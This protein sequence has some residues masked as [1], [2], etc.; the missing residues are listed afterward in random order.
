[1]R[2]VRS[3]PHGAFV[4]AL[5]PFV[6]PS[7]QPPFQ[8]WLDLHCALTPGVQCGLVMSMPA[9]ARASRPAEDGTPASAGSPAVAATWPRRL[10]G[11]QELEQLAAS[12]MRRG[13]LAVHRPGGADKRILMAHPLS[14][15]G[16]SLLSA[17]AISFIPQLPLSDDDLAA[18]GRRAQA[19]LQLLS[20]TQDPTGLGH[21]A[22]ALKVL[23]CTL[24]QRHAD[25][26]ASACAD[27]LLAGLGCE[28]VA[29][30]LLQGADL[31]FA[32][33]APALQMDT[34]LPLARAINAAMH[35][36]LDQE[37]PVLLNPALPASADEPRAPIRLMH[38]QLA[39]LEPGLATLSVP[40]AVEGKPA[41]VV[42]LQRRAEA[43]FDA[44]AALL[45]DTV[46]ALAGPL[47]RM[48]QQLH[49][50]WPQRL[51]LAWHGRLAGR[52]AAP[53]NRRRIAIAAGLVVT[54]A[55]GLVPID[56]RIS[57][58]ARVEGAVERSLAAPVDGFIRE[59]SALPGDA[60][61]SGQVLVTLDDED[62]TIELQR[63]EGELGQAESQY[64]DA[65][66]R[67]DR[68]QIAVQHAR[69]ESARAQRDL[70]Q[71]QLSRT[72]LV[73]P[74]DATVTEGDLSRAIGSPVKRGDVLVKL[75]P[76]ADY[77]LMLDVDERD[78]AQVALGAKG[79]VTLAAASDRNLPVTVA[80]VSPVSVARDGHNVFEVEAKLNAADAQLRPGL[81][82][83]ARLDAGQRPLAAV[84]LRRSWDW[85]RLQAWSWFG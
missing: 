17:G 73:A 18:I 23:A 62:A 60:V 78:I 38:G 70:A 68:A 53:R 36:A 49:G 48:K 63:A 33:V 26:A 71:R 56:F 34:R 41:G 5:N 67:Q 58:Q 6:D 59:V 29:I 39:R 65:V 10:Q 14:Q 55:V 44:H 3:V 85:L 12:A 27:E 37:V 31:R 1:M 50:P 2:H 46:M 19:W 66:G 51:R 30:A 45:V 15:P 61:K 40:F 7:M 20:T 11:A 24:Q 69:M 28:R 75:V 57:A 64:N 72:R 82:G 9:S 32:A 84:L 79:G 42:T 47:L 77:R 74:F 80:R 54:L 4:F 8:T 35:E 22:L 81:E 21:A 25:A 43:P 16:G 13:G 83:V 52:A 76:G